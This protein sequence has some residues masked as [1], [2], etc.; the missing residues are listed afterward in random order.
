[1]VLEES[2]IQ[3]DETVDW[4]RWS[5]GRYPPMVSRT[6]QEVGPGAH[7]ASKIV[8]KISLRGGPEHGS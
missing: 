1:M 8:A 6:R 2:T 7:R 4:G 5:R 3:M